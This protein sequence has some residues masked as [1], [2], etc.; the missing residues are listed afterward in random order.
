[1]TIYTDPKD[2]ALVVYDRLLSVT[3]KIGFMSPTEL[4]LLRERVNGAGYRTITR[5][6]V[7]ALI[8]SIEEET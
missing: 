5:D 4:S 3:A 6:C 8:D 1:M 7:L 2:N